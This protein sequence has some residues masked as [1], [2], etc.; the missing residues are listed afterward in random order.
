MIIVEGGTVADHVRTIDVL[1]TETRK[2]VVNHV[3]TVRDMSDDR[4]T[5]SELGR[6]GADVRFPRTI[7]VRTCSV[8]T[9][10]ERN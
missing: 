1:M 9:R 2:S 4:V 3:R 7:G 5:T 8:S 6:K 10:S